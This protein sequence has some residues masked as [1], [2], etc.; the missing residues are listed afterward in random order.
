MPENARLALR[1][2]I[3]SRYRNALPIP[4]EEVPNPLGA[5]EL[6]LVVSLGRRL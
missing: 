5:Q 3:V 4:E 1:G 2:C 6:R